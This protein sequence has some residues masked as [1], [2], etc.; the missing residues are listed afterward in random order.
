MYVC[1]YMYM[2]VSIDRADASSPASIE[3]TRHVGTRSYRRIADIVLSVCMKFAFSHTGQTDGKE[4]GKEKE[5]REG[6]TRF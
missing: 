2:Y 1:M 6:S 4:G 3:C 5:E